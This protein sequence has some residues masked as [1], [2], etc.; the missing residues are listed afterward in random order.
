[1]AVRK[2]CPIS[3]ESNDFKSGKN[4]EIRVAEE[5]RLRNVIEDLL[6]NTLG[7]GKVRA[8]VALDMNF[9]RVVTN[10]EMYDPDGA[11]V[12]SVQSVDEREQTPVSS[13]NSQDAS[14]ANN[15]PGGG[16]EGG[17]SGQQFA[18]T[19]KSDQTTNYEISKTIKNH[20]PLKQGLRQPTVITLCLAAL[21]ALWG[22]YAWSAAGAIPKLPL[23]KP[24]ALPD[25]GLS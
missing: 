4:E 15:I 2:N 9:D 23:L 3:D 1:M 11:V 10:S 8:R 20:I 25:T 6:T 24:R 22:A 18:L 5:N 21:F 14:V 13:L 17:G 7:A 19:E 16:A 12:R